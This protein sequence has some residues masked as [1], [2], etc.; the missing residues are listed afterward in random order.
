MNDGQALKGDTQRMWQEAEVYEGQGLYD[1]AVAVYRN[2]LSKDPENR[3]AQAKVVQIN[4]A[5]KMAE[6]AIGPP[7]P[8][9]E[10]SP[11]LSTDL[12]LAYMGMESFR[13]GSGRIQQV[14]SRVI[15][16]SSGIGAIYVCLFRG[17]SKR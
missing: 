2:I 14:A 13:R 4:F 15:G 12:G 7:T 3:K 1:Q 16:V 11:R 6:T 9:E 17:P 5:R 8:L 10:L